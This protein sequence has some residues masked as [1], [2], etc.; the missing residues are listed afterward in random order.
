MKQVKNATTGNVDIQ[1]SA[2]LVSIAEKPLLNT[3]KKEYYPCTIDF[4]D[5]KGVDRRAS[6]IIYGAN[7]AHGMSPGNHYLATATKGE[8]G[9]FIQVSHLAGGGVRATEEMFDFSNSSVTKVE[10]SAAGTV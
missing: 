3:N 2:K 5:A 7:L 8:Q 4:V 1:F 10:T 9:V 6:G